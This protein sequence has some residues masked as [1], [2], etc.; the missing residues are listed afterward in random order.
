MPDD[1]KIFQ[2]KI[3]LLGIS[4]MI[5]RRVLVSS[6]TTLRELHG[7]LQVAMGWEGIHLFQFDI[8]AVEYG[9]W[10][11]RAADPDIPLN[12][13]RFRRNDRISYIYD[14]GAYWKHEVRVEAILDADP[15]KSYLVCAGGA[16]VCPPEDCGGPQDYLARRDEANGYDAWQDLE[17]LASF[18]QELL[19][20]HNTGQ[21]LEDLPLD[22]LEYVLDRMKAREPYLEASFTRRNVN[23]Q[24]REGRHRK[25]MH[26][27][28]I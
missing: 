9:S 11:L 19:D 3:R 5:W 8:R 14:M 17:A 7:I 23:A 21:T 10:E 12:D 16:G 25:L 27:Q 26:Q 24:L 4:P 22:D 6:F 20:H 18:G 13:F 2:L 28:L 15:K 1:A